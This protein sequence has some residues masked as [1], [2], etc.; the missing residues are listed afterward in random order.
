MHLLRPPARSP[1]RLVLLALALAALTPLAW[2][3]VGEQPELGPDTP[4]HV[5]LVWTEAPQTRALLAWST[6]GAP[7]QNRVYYHAEKGDKGGRESK[8]RPLSEYSAH[9]D[10]QVN[11]A[12]TSSDG[13]LHYHHAQLGDLHPDT[14]YRCTIVSG[15]ER[16]AD[17]WFRTAPAEDVPV[18]FLQGGDSRSDSAQRRI[19]NGWI[20]DLVEDQP[21]TLCLTHS[22]DYI[23]RGTR[24]DQWVQWMTDHELTT[25]D[26]GR[27]VPIV[28]TRGNHEATGE[29]YD[30]VFGHPGGG[31]GKNYFVTMLTPD[32][33]FI[34][35][36]TEVAAGGPQT[37]FLEAAIAEHE[38]AQWRIAQ[39]HRPFFPAVKRPA[40]ARAHWQPVFDRARFDLVCEGDGHTLRRTVPV[41]G[42][43]PHDD[44]II[45]LGEG[46]LGVPQRTPKSERWYLQA[47]GFA[48]SAHHVWRLTITDEVAI[49]EAIGADDAILHRFERAPRRPVEGADQRPTEPA[50]AAVLAKRLD[51]LVST[52]RTEDPLDVQFEVESSGAVDSTVTG[53]LRVVDGTLTLTFEGKFA[54]RSID[55]TLTGTADKL[56]LTSSNGRG[57]ENEAPTALRDGI[58]V[59]FVRMG[60][61]H[62][63]AMMSGGRAPDRVDG[64]ASEWAKSRNC[65][66][67]GDGVAFD[68]EVSGKPAGSAELAFD[69]ETGLPTRRQQTVEFGPGKT[70]NVVETY[71]F[72]TPTKDH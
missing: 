27:L 5:R 52:L 28:P 56:T 50:P 21:E 24:L 13:A 39:Y 18:T 51:D 38:G 36:N 29:I 58:A 15:E 12:Y 2:P 7:P 68:I 59:G 10:A 41:R 46:G 60:I 30:E 20:A 19:I 25:T 1:I 67:M 17:F 61:L 6:R 45:Y 16:S 42:D 8:R 11:G 4:H 49:G 26:D 48:A 64:T 3:Q 33:L 71:T 63:I 35:L 32:V 54:G 43:A 47:P 69:P 14:I 65:R 34:T 31:L 22:G 44:G 37:E 66:A 53:S 72:S 62:N 9:V 40:R 70:M 57:F 23:F 55:G